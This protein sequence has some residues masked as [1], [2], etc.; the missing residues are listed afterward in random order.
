MITAEQRAVCEKFRTECVPSREDYKVGI[1]AN[2][3]DGILPI[4]GL[5]HT[6]EGETTGWYIW[7]GEEFSTDPDFFSPL[8]VKHVSDW[9]PAVL[10]FLALPPGWRFL[11]AEGYEDVWFDR[12][13]LAEEA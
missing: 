11:L 10:R 13:L 7:A 4:N 12:S 3:K 8:H 2:V 6:P 5:R 9:C 1:A